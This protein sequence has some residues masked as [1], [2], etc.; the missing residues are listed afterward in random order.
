MHPTSIW[1]REGTIQIQTMRHAII[2][3]GRRPIKAIAA[4][5]VR[6]GFIEQLQHKLIIVH[7]YVIA[8]EKVR[9]HIVLSINLSAWARL[10]VLIIQFREWDVSV[11]KKKI[12][13]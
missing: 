10:G 6:I 5:S 4:P 2:I 11:I 7:S 3:H 12:V 8:S 1:T 13:G 9:N